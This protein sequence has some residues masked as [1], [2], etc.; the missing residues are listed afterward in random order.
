VDDNSANCGPNMEQLIYHFHPT[1]VL[2][3]GTTGGQYTIQLTM[4]TIANNLNAGTCT[5]CTPNLLQILN[6][7][8]NS[9][10]GT[11]NSVGKIIDIITTK[12]C[13]YQYPTNKLLL[14]N[15][16]TFSQINKYGYDYFALPK[17]LNETYMYSG[18]PLTL[19]P[20]LSAETCDFTGKLGYGTN[21]PSS[22]N[23]AKNGGSYIK[24]TSATA[25]ITDWNNGPGWENYKLQTKL[26]YNDFNWFDIY[27]VDSGIVTYIDTNYII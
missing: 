15:I 11:T 16:Q 20:S 5:N 21:F 22:A 3:T 25:V 7:I 17:Y 4:P 9:S 18:S 8:N 27:V 19:I 1:T 13:R 14:G 26:T 2:T 23:I 24:Q 12:S 6:N 10:T